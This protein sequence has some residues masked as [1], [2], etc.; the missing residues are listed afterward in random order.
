MSHPKVQFL[1]SGFW[2]L[3]SSLNS[4]FRILTSSQR[5]VHMMGGQIT[6]ESAPGKGSTFEL[7]LPAEILMHKGTD[8]KHTAAAPTYAASRHAKGF[9]EACTD[10]PL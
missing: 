7:Q 3:N 1:Y 5:F 9:Q 10:S 4:G 6:V 8:T 2:L